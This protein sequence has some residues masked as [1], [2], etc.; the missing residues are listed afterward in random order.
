MAFQETEIEE[1]AENARARGLSKIH[2]LR[3][4][5]DQEIAYKVSPTQVFRKTTSV[6]G[7]HLRELEAFPCVLCVLLEFT[8]T[9]HY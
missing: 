4:S 9:F 6:I 5:V 7:R 1:F 3:S 8:Y 2:D